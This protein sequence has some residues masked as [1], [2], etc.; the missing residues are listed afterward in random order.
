MIPFKKATLAILLLMIILIPAAVALQKT[1]A[2][3]EADLVNVKPIAIDPDRETVFYTYGKPL[4]SSGQWQTTYDDA[5][6]YGIEITASD[7]LTRT[8]ER[9]ILT[10]AEKSLVLRLLNIKLFFSQ[11]LLYGKFGIIDFLNS[12]S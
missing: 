10:V 3:Q 9:I 7:G 2:V 6:E 8:T 11:F 4:N 5:G 12:V 1:F